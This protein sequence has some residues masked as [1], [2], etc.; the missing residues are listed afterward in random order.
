MSEY[1]SQ[2]CFPQF[3]KLSNKLFITGSIHIDI[4]QNNE[5]I[6]EIRR[7]I[8]VFSF[9]KNMINFQLKIIH[10]ILILCK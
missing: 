9:L 5:F 3:V 10:I 4:R 8:V 7:I 6:S 1:N 2:F